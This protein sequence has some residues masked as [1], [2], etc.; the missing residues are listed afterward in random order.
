VALEALVV[1]GLFGYG[2]SGTG[3]C[4]DV[5]YIEEFMVKLEKDTSYKELLRV[6]FTLKEFSFWRRK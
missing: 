4:R 3:K 1:W 2:E 6:S 5:M